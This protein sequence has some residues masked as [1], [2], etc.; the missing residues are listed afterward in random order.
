MEYLGY[1]LILAAL[2]PAII[3]IRHSLR[4]RSVSGISGTTTLAWVCSWSVWILY[5]FLVSSGPMIAR[6]ILGLVPAAV[7]LVVFCRISRLSFPLLTAGL[8]GLAAGCMLFDVRLGLLVMVVLDVYFYLPSVLKVFRSKNLTGVSLSANATQV[9]LCSSW[10][11]YLLLSGNAAA[12]VGYAVAS[13]TYSVIVLRLLFTKNS[14]KAQSA[15]LLRKI[16]AQV[17]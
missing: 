13:A 1:A 5:G 11:T 15:T 2:L 12:G 17:V 10:F 14:A 9:A 6:N 4:L 3:Q 16:P 7:L 8:Y